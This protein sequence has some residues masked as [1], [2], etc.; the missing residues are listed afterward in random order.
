MYATSRHNSTD[1]E[2]SSASDPRSSS[3]GG[4]PGPGPSV[5]P[6]QLGQQAVMQFDQKKTPVYHH[7]KDKD[8][9]DIY[10]W[11]ER[12]EAM[13]TSFQWSDEATYNNAKSSLFGVAARY[14][15][16]WK[17]IDPKFQENWTYYKPKLQKEF[18]YKKTRLVQYDAVHKMPIRKSIYDSIESYVAQVMDNMRIVAD[19][20]PKPAAQNRLTQ[21]GAV[22]YTD[23][24]VDAL[25]L[26]HHE[27]LIHELRIIYLLGGLTPEVRKRL[28]EETI[29]NPDD[30]IG[31]IK[32][33]EDNLRTSAQN[34]PQIHYAEET[35]CHGYQGEY[36]N[37][38]PAVNATTGGYRGSSNRGRGGRGQNRGNSKQSSGRNET[39]S[40]AN[41]KKCVYCN[42]S[43]HGVRE[44]FSRIRDNQPVIDMDGKS[45]FPASDQE[46]RNRKG[47]NKVG[48][49][50]QEQATGSGFRLWA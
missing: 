8:T 18:G 33:H 23:A 48:K 16:A 19:T 21:A 4:N 24:D 41:A 3:S 31:K 6:V 43:G 22:P 49:I 38:L 44:C 39:A 42:K 28:L 5:N 11:I 47:W 1:S 7:E 29:D 36:E 45:F 25:I 27:R 37:P 30:F 17:E 50:E 2:G 14:A 20:M 10:E 40:S 26:Q 46:T 34:R 12:I 15:R 13:R 32:E 9:L 35:E